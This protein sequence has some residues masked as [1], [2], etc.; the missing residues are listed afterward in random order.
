MAESVEGTIEI[1]A[2]IDA[3]LA[4]ICDF[5]HYTEWSK[6]IKQV[7]VVK[8]DASKRGKHVRFVIDAVVLKAEYVLDYSYLP[9]NSG[10]SWTC[11]EAKG[12]IRDLSGAYEL[13]AIDDDRTEVTYRTTT[14]LAMPLPGFLKKQG[15]KRARDVAL[16]GLKKR[17]ESQRS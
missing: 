9:G 17:V 13:H 4:E 1:E 10:V 6:E 11:V 3:V 2:P 5:E 14:E 8:R 7:E 15:A 16:Q 12:G